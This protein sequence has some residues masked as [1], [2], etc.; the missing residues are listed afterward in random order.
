MRYSV[1][2]LFQHQ[3]TNSDA[4]A[5]EVSLC[6]GEQ[7]RGSSLRLR[8]ACASI[9]TFVL[10]V[11]LVKQD[12]KFWFCFG[13][14]RHTSDTQVVLSLLAGLTQFTCFTS[15]KAQI[16]TQKA[17]QGMPR[18]RTPKRYTK[19]QPRGCCRRRGSSQARKSKLTCQKKKTS[20]KKA[21]STSFTKPYRHKR[22]NSGRFFFFDSLGRRGLGC[23]AW[24]ALVCVQR[25]EGA[26][27]SHAPGSLFLRCLSLHINVYTHTLYLSLSLR[28][29]T[30]THTNIHT[31][32]HTQY[33]PYTHTHTHEH[34]HTRTHTRTSIPSMFVYKAEKRLLRAT[35]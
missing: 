24:R 22:K 29:H 6:C 35:L 5:A 34:T 21:C 33:S 2:L 25:G 10:L 23:L 7:S 16:L 19:T 27:A 32:E 9:C 17:V 13:L 8:Q 30:H 11:K 18:T 26:V 12:S 1:Y 20:P 28:I 3:S 31:H 15:T 14:L 4:A